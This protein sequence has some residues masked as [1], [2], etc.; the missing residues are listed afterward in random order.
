MKC[1]VTKF[2]I[3]APPCHTMS[4]FVDPPPHPLTCDVIY[5]CPLRRTIDRNERRRKK[6]N[7][8]PWWFEEQKKILGIK[9]GSWRSEKMETTVYQSNISIFHK[10]M[11]PLISS[12]FNNNNL[13][14]IHY[15]VFVY[16][17]MYSVCLH[18]ILCQ[19][20]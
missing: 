7:T 3:P 8:A 13:S 20:F 6:T 16:I 18:I 11:D 12:M 5:G 19:K 4:H 17:F 9:G 1:D 14:N 10:S 15:I 2:R